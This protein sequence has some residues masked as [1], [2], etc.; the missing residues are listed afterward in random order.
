MEKKGRKS[1][2]QEH[3][4]VKGFARTKLLH[5]LHLSFNVGLRLTLCKKGI[6]S[7]L[8]IQQQVL[9]CAQGRDQHTLDRIYEVI[10]ES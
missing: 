3:A 10:R 6:K 4:L 5:K 1:I 8:R 2:K 9:Y 7:L